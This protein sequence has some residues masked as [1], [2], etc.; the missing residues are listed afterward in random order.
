MNFVEVVDENGDTTFINMDD[1]SSIRCGI[2]DFPKGISAGITFHM[3]N[4]DYVLLKYKTFSHYEA[5]DNPEEVD[6]AIRSATEYITKVLEN[7]H[8]NLHN[9]FGHDDVQ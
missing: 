6:E 5:D 4:N 8:V 3:K 9:I 2:T 1:V 7:A